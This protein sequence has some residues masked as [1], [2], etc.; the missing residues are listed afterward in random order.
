M[1]NLLNT[2]I[3]VTIF[4]SCFVIFFFEV[5]LFYLLLLFI[6]S[7]AS[8]SRAF[9]PSLVPPDQSDWCICFS[10]LP[11]LTRLIPT[12][13]SVCHSL[14][15]LLIPSFFFFFNLMPCQCLVL[16]FECLRFLFSRSWQKLHKNWLNFTK[17]WYFAMCR[18][19]GL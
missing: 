9:L 1:L 15:V 6:F 13:S 18:C 14:F 3:Y 16:I 7:S 10:S 5:F 11:V 19:S 4:S 8:F 12:H 17:M 2:W